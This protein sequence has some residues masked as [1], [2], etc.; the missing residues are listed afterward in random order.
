VLSKNRKIFESQLYIQEVRIKL[1][2]I[3][4]TLLLRILSFL[5]V[6]I[7]G[8]NSID[9]AASFGRIGYFLRSA[10][11][12]VSHL[13]RE[14]SESFTLF[15]EGCIEL[16]KKKRRE[17]LEKVYI[18][19]KLDSDYFPPVL[20]DQFFGAIGHNAITGIHLAA[21]DLGILPRG[22]RVGIV[23]EKFTSLEHIKLYKEK[24]HLVNYR[25][26]SGWTELPNNW[27]LTERH[28]MIR[29]FGTFLDTY[30][31][32]DT[33]FGS[34]AINTDN[35]LFELTAEY[36]ENSMANLRKYGFKEDDWFVGIHIRDGGPIPE[37][38]N[39]NIANYIPAIKEIV[40]RGGWVIRI[41]DG[42]MPPLPKMNKVIDLAIEEDARKKLHLFIIAK[43]RFFI[44]TCSGPLYFPSL[45]G[46][47]TLG[48]N[49]IGLGRT[50]L[51]FASN[52]FHIPKTYLKRNNARP[53]LD[54]MLKSPFGFGELSM[55]EFA[56]LGIHVQENSAI[57]IEEGVVEMFLRVSGLYLPREDE[58][59]GK[60]N[61]IRS[62]FEWTS[63]GRIS[64]SFLQRHET[65]L[66]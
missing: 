18:F 33:V 21:Q 44:A 47:P 2:R 17:T 58:F 25:E 56:K 19:N 30:E 42:R 28:Q 26:G 51:T 48:T 54:E 15:N 24:L 22:K 65:S 37:L 4:Q 11:I 14:W 40:R 39:Q 8:N 10:E 13:S 43:S 12:D 60:V 66:F 6:G 31:L 62:Q 34:Q 38:R 1:Q 3:L 41:G 5:Y 45:F 36:I 35:P 57:E 27:H 52:S 49:M 53:T 23:P 50:T 61:D 63:K 7:W 32:V 64:N 16:A 59:S 55:N 29:G 9:D 46:V 20:S